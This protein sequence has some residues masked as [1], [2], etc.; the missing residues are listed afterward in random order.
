LHRR[1]TIPTSRSL[2]SSL[3][4]RIMIYNYH[5]DDPRKCTS[6][7]LEKFRL[8][9]SLRGLG[10][11]PREAIVLNPISNTTMSFEDRTAIERYGLVGLDC[12]WNRADEVFHNLKGQNRRLPTL[13]AGNPTNYSV[14]SRLSTVEALAAALLIAGFRARAQELLAIFSWGETFLTLN[15]D[16]LKEYSEIPAGKMIECEREYFPTE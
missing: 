6:A 10:Q 2:E 9:E 7:R 5:Q 4:P 16:P 11:I 12:S 13:L 3:K 14:R 15:K 8:V 1:T